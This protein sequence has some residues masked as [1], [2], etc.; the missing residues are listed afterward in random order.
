MAT[1]LSNTGFSAIQG[2]TPMW[3]PVAWPEQAF[4]LSAIYGGGAANIISLLGG[5]L[6]LPDTSTCWQDAAG[7]VPGAYDKKV[8]LMNDVTGLFTASQPT[9]N[10]RP[11]LRSANYSDLP[12]T[13]ATGEEWTTTRTLIDDA[14]GIEW[15][16]GE[17]YWRNPAGTTGNYA[18]TPDSAAASITGDL[19]LIVKITRANGVAEQDC[20]TGKYN[21][22]GNNRSYRL[23]V[24]SIDKLVLITTSD[25]STILI[26]QTTNPVDFTAGKYFTATLDVNDGSG[27]RVY[28][29]KQ[30]SDGINWATLES[31][32]TV[33]G[34]TTIYDGTSEVEIGS[35]NLGALESFNGKI[36]YA[37]AWANITG[38]G[39]PAWEFH[40]TRDAVKPASPWLDFDGT[41]DYLIS[42]IIPG[43]YS[44]GFICAGA[45]QTEAIGVT[46]SIFGSADSNA[47]RG[48]RF[49]VNATGKI[50]MTRTSGSA[51][52]AVSASPSNIAKDTP[53]FAT[54]SYWVAGAKVGING[55]S[56]TVNAITCDYTGSTQYALIGA[57]NDTESGVTPTIYMQG[58]IHALSWLPSIPTEAQ[59]TAI[60]NYVASKT[61]VT[62]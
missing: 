48:V 8:A 1:G 38:E 19:T 10:Y 5:A 15:E 2:V 34:T 24:N 29:F 60:R 16:N 31:S 62:L 52:A 13:S 17:A 26:G 43:N 18:S 35:Y 12:F 58:H 11:Y 54:A 4:G 21:T 6:Y 39:T 28:T 56:P 46:N 47:V 20:I 7:T 53:F 50:A 14:G 42:S 3:P 61:G 45:V 37:A 32:S 40:P 49:V 23:I 55:E 59:E 33:S 25:G 51:T 57:S 30:S 27:N 22:S 36:H 41:D 9:T 44:E